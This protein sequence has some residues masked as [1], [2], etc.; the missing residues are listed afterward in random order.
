MGRDLRGA[1]ERSQSKHGEA[2]A[3]LE[4]KIGHEH[5]ANWSM[6][7]SAVHRTVGSADA[8]QASNTRYHSASEAIRVSCD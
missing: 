7:E 3:T 6:S 4:L 1:M 5:G 8:S 2:G